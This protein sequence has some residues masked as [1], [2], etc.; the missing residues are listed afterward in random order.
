MSDDPWI[1][2]TSPCV[3]TRAHSTGDNVSDKT[4]DTNNAIMMV[5]ASGLNILP[6]IP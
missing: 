6:S 5:Y 4:S 3:S 2:F 1:V